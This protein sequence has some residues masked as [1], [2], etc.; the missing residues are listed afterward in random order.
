MKVQRI[1]ELMT[2]VKIEYDKD[3]NNWRILRG[4]D[5]DQHINTFI[6]HDDKKLWQLKTEWKNP[7]VPLGVGKAVKRNLNDEIEELMSTGTDLLIHEMYPDSKNLII[8]LG[9]GKYSQQATD[10]LT[11]LLR[12]N[13]SSYAKNVEAEF[14]KE[15]NKILRE[16]QIYN[17]YI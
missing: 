12:Q 11:D 1:S 10:Q 16:E 7:V 5:K 13:R 6:A 8:A 4:K 14:N 2:E 3:P 15:L 9:I 17:H